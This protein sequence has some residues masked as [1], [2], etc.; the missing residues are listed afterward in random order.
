MQGGGDFHGENLGD[1]ATEQRSFVG[2]RP[3]GIS[4]DRVRRND[5]HREK[6]D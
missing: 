3:R 1:V 6:T 4:V 5:F 2:F